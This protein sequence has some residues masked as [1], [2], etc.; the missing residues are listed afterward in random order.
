MSGGSGPAELA[1]IRSLGSTAPA[2][3]R[4]RDVPRGRP[5]PPRGAFHRR[6]DLVLGHIERAQ[7]R[8]SPTVGDRLGTR[9]PD[10]AIAHLLS[11]LEDIGLVEQVEDALRGKRGVFRIAE[12]IVRLHQLLIQRHEAELV[13]R[14][15][16]QVWA[17]NADTVAA[18]IYGTH[19]EE[20][21]RQWCSSTLDGHPRRRRESGAP[22][23]TSL[24]GTPQGT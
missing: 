23:G 2:Q 5:P 21:S 17:A 19:F 15:A 8:Q 24:P 10:S 9:S 22:N 4:L 7:R 12:P 6:P 3:P 20:L 16:G 14:R 18:K 13:A 1:G 11:G